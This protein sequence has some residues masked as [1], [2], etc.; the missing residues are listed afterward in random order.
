MSY[1]HGYQFMLSAVQ[2]AYC[3][4]DLRKLIAEVADD[5]WLKDDDD[6]AVRVMDIGGHGPMKTYVQHSQ[7]LLAAF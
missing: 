6:G 2:A 3:E 4:D 7:P 1:D 5:Q